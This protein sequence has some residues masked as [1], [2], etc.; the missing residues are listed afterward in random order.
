MQ[1]Y[2]IIIIGSG[3]GG[4]ICGAVLS[5]EGYSVCIVEK[6]AQTGGC[7]QSFKRFG[8]TLDTGIHYIGS[9]DEG[10]ILHRTFTYLDIMDKVNLIRMNENNFDQICF[11]DKSYSY[12]MGS[13]RFVTTLA[14]DFPKEKENIQRYIQDI[15]SI[16]HTISPEVFKKG[17]ISTATLD[18][19]SISAW[20]KI[21][22]TTN[23]EKLRQVLSNPVMLYGGDKNTSTFYIHSMIVWSYLHGSYR[24]VGSS[25]QMTDALVKK[26]EENGGTVMTQAEVTKIHCKNDTVSG[27]ELGNGKLLETKYVISTLHPLATLQM[28]EKTISIRKAYLTRLASLTNSYGFFT[29][30]LIKKKNSTPYLNNN[31]YLYADGQD[32]WHKTSFP[33]NDKEIKSVM[34][35]MKPSTDNP[36]Y[37][38]AIEL[39]TPMFFSEVEQWANTL[40]ERRGDAYREFKQ[41]KAEEIILFAKQFFPDIDKHTEHVFTTTPLSYRDYT[42]S[43]EGSAYG[44]MKNYHNP[45]ASL[46]PIRSKVKNMLF[47]GQNV[48]M[49]GVLGVTLTS[50]LNCAEFLGENYIAKKIGNIY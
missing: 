25:I 1:K 11:P 9:L 24:F 32:A 34:I 31:F 42:G 28:T 33:N 48:N 5:K 47:A 41:K 21:S 19:F 15:S 22:E 40:Y 20:K 4:L 3:L 29:A 44:I 43:P 38:D 14:Q 17:K 50:L 46:I 6:N 36:Y 30:Y 16:A 7:F 13:E 27:V 23:N 26:I 45:I 37:T 12:A 8:R 49:P 10:E 39:L 2:D 18:V 35:S